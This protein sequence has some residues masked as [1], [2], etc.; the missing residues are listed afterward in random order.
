VEQLDLLLRTNQ[1]G[2]PTQPLSVHVPSDWIAGETM[3][4]VT[5][6]RRAPRK[7]RK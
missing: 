5:K 1:H 4:V 2:I 6:K 3:P 7:S